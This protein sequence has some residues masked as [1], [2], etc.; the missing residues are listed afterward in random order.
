MEKHKAKIE[1]CVRPPNM[2]VPTEHI[3]LP[4]GIQGQQNS[5]YLDATLYGMFAFSDAFDGL[6][7]EREIG[8]TNREIQEIIQQNIV[9]PLRKY[10]FACIRNCMYACAINFLHSLQIMLWS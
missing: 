10:V 2:L 5:C 8:G 7:L 3:G 4:K 1:T 6:F 9:Y